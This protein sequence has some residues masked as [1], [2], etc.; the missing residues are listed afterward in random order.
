[1]STE[2]LINDM[3][4]DVEPKPRVRVWPRLLAAGLA[5]LIV[6]ALSVYFFY[7][8]RTDIRLTAGAVFLKDL[9]CFAVIIAAAPI[10]L[11]LSRPNTGIL[12]QSIPIFVLIAI[13]LAT[14]GF[15]VAMAPA[16][17]RLHIWMAEGVP[18][19]LWNI[20]LLAAPISA[21]LYCVVRNL[22]PTRLMLAGAA[23]G[24]LSGA[25]AGLAYSWFCPVDSIPYI[26]TWYL[27]SM[28][29]CAGLGALAGRWFLRW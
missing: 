3:A 19:S 15:V 29:I 16:K 22:S 24:G 27:A 9:Y 1:V 2:A 20:P 4:N 11:L 10:L 7:G 28:L 23:L 12:R 5:G 13:S 18:A 17:E 14:A 6:A 26:A 21:I 25:V 8:I